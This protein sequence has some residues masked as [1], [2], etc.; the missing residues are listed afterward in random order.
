MWKPPL[1]QL[2]HNYRGCYFLVYG[3]DNA[4]K[5]KTPF[6]SNKIKFQVPESGI[7][8]TSSSPNDNYS[9]PAIFFDS[10]LGEIHKLT[11]PFKRYDLILSSDTLKCGNQEYLWYHIWI[12]KD[13]PNWSAKEDSINRLNLKLIEACNLTKTIRP[14]ANIGLA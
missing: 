14:A 3:V 5:L 1:V 11:P 13:E 7:I 6:Y 12:I 9:D 4:P 8:L 10:T 2:P